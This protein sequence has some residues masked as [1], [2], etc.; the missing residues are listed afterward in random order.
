MQEKVST[1]SFRSAKFSVNCF[2]PSHTRCWGS[3]GSNWC[4]SSV[5][6]LKPMAREE[7]NFPTL[8][9][10]CSAL[11][12]MNKHEYLVPRELDSLYDRLRRCKEQFYFHKLSLPK[13]IMTSLWTSFSV[14]YRA[15]RIFITLT[16]KVIGKYFS[17]SHFLR[18]FDFKSSKTKLNF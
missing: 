14:H 7:K 9:N 16:L 13:L 15:Q 10:S 6:K 8:L 5:N 2:S 3:V 4:Q 11:F 18:L 17:P 12:Y 1:I